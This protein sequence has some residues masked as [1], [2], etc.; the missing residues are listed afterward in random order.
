MRRET[1]FGGMENSFTLSTMRKT[2][3]T[4]LRLADSPFLIFW[5]T[6]KGALERPF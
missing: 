2:S 1:I 5:F 6:M 3:A 4:S